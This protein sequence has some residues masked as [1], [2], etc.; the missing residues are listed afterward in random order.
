MTPPK[1]RKDSV[2]SHRARH[3]LCVSQSLSKDR[4]ANLIMTMR[5]RSLAGDW[6]HIL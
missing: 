6:A 5:T 4:R 2:S 1:N 3:H